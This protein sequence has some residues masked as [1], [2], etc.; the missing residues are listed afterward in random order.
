MR[1][2]IISSLNALET[3]EVTAVIGYCSDGSWK[4]VPESFDN[5]ASKIIHD[6]M[7]TDLDLIIMDELGFFESDALIFQ[8]TVHECL[9]FAIPV[10][11]VLKDKSTIF[12]DSVRSRDDTSIL[13]LYETDR[14]STYTQL[15]FMLNELMKSE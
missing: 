11:G 7:H 8:K 5:F 3:D 12:L 15:S 13:T 14:E 1:G 10:L 6:S 2:F 4:A 9:D